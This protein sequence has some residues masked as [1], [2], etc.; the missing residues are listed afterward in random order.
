MST[1]EQNNPSTNRTKEYYLKVRYY[2]LLKRIYDDLQDNEGNFVDISLCE[3]D[4]NNLELY[5]EVLETMVT[6]I[7]II[8]NY[9]LHEET[10]TMYYGSG[11]QPDLEPTEAD[12]K[13]DF[14]R[15]FNPPGSEAIKTCED[16]P[17]EM[18]IIFA[19]I[20]ISDI[21]KNKL[22][23]FVDKIFKD[24][25]KIKLIEVLI[26]ERDLKIFINNRYDLPIIPR[27]TTHENKYWRAI[28]EIMKNGEF[29]MI[30]VE[31]AKNIVKYFNSNKNNPIY[32]KDIFKITKI[33]KERVTEE[34][35]SIISPELGIQICSIDQEKINR[36]MG[37]KQKKS[38]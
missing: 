14:T 3:I 27:N 11:I 20:K 7:K 28:T 19:K 25:K 16:I 32:T 31:N 1:E 10:E 9:E 2:E 36:S 13:Y 26:E 33:L 37:Q 4:D 18:E 5:K 6:K 15:Y 35:E 34:G 17:R 29:K 24:K 22:N 12:L 8:N 23:K 30:G 38:G 21:N